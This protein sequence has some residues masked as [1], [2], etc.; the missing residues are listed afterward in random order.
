MGTMKL[1]QRFA[2]TLPP[3]P[4]CGNDLTMSKHGYDADNLVRHGKVTP[5]SPLRRP[6]AA[7]PE[8]S[9][10]ATFTGTARAQASAA[11]RTLGI[12]VRPDE[13]DE[14]YRGP[15]QYRIWFAG[16]LVLHCTTRTAQSRTA[17]FS[18]VI[19]YSRTHDGLYQRHKRRRRRIQP[20]RI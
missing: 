1:S 16:G 4:R 3:L 7:L 14:K 19:D 5:L 12:E 18:Y 20:H 8:S 15:Q 9:A 6:Q 10:L 13:W 17:R 2:A 11:L